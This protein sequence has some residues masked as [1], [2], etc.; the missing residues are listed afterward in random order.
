MKFLP[1]KNKDHVFVSLRSVWHNTII[2]QILIVQSVRFP[3]YL[4]FYLLF[5]CKVFAVSI[6]CPIIGY[7]IYLIL[8]CPF[9]VLITFFILVIFLNINLSIAHFTRILLLSFDF[10]FKLHIHLSLRHVTTGSWRC[11][12]QVG[13]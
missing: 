1:P 12:P 9:Y 2:R 13:K 4:C 8:V 3:L 5:T 10:L 6:F 11:F 7:M